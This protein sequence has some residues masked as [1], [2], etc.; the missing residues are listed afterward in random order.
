MGCK[1]SKAAANE[2]PNEDAAARNDGVKSLSQLSAVTVSLPKIETNAN[3]EK[4]LQAT[5]VEVKIV[6][7]SDKGN[8]VVQRTNSKTTGPAPPRKVPSSAKLKQTAVSSSSSGMAT[9]A[10]V[11]SA[12]EPAK[13]PTDSAN[14]TPKASG[15]TKENASNKIKVAKNSNSTTAAID[16][17]REQEYCA[18]GGEAI[19]FD[20]DGD[21]S[22]KR[23]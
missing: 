21:I 1:N 12:E 3:T 22:K 10:P 23:I 14:S 15:R 19:V 20:A 9:S 13:K 8:G 18:T 16:S 17:T 5:N 2:K 11:S 7:A 4:V 6:G